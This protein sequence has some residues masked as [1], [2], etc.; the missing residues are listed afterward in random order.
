MVTVVPSPGFGTF[1]PVEMDEYPGTC[2][3]QGFLLDSPDLRAISG[4]S[5]NNETRNNESK[6]IRGSFVK[7]L[8][9]FSI[10]LAHED[11]IHSSWNFSLCPS[12]T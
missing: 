10:G 1:S 12:S 3:K 6:Q 9:P 5:V 11:C 2:F 8:L 4:Y 7:L